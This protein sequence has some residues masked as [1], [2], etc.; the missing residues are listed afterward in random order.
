M[1]AAQS[2]PRSDGGRMCGAI[3]TYGAIMKWVKKLN[4]PFLLGLEGFVLGAVLFF[5]THPGTADALIDGD[6][7]AAA[8]GQASEAA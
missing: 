6:H 4:N 8:E 3:R 1:A 5:S 2:A 7:A